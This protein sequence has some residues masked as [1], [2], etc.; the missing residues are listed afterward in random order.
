MGS[1][2]LLAFNVLWQREIQQSY[3]SCGPK[4]VDLSQSGVTRV[5]WDDFSALLF[6]LLREKQ[7]KAALPL[8][9]P[10]CTDQP[11]LPAEETAAAPGESVW[12]VS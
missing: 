7:K 2:S 5:A 1:Y 11:D 4:D 12:E 6:L 9:I 10:A 8:A 3:C